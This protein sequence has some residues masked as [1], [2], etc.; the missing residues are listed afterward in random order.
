MSSS[1]HISGK[2]TEKY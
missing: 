2:N 1:L